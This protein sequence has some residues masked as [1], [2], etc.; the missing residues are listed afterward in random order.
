MEFMKTAEI[1]HL[2]KRVGTLRMKLAEVSGTLEGLAIILEN[3]G[4]THISEGLKKKNQ[5]IN[6]LLYGKDFV[7]DL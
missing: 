4:K 6:E 7:R 2:K 1:K 5:E 3:E